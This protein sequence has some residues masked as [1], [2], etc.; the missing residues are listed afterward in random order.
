MRKRTAAFRFFLAA[1]LAVGLMP[2]MAFADGAE[3]SAKV[4]TEDSGEGRS[5]ASA[6]IEG[7]E[8]VGA[9][10]EGGASDASSPEES[11]DTTSDATNADPEEVEGLTI[12]SRPSEEVM[13]DAM[14]TLEA[15]S[16]SGFQAGML[17]AA[18]S[19]KA[20][21]PIQEYE[22]ADRFE[23]ACNVAEAAYPD[24]VS[25]AIIAGSEGWADALSATALAG[26]L[27]CPILLTEAD[28]LNE[29]T[30]STL[31]VLGVESVLIVGGPNTVSVDVEEALS[32][33]GFEVEK[34]LGGAD[35]YDV[36]MGIYEYG[37]G[38]WGDSAVIVASGAKF[39]DALSASPLAFSQ[40][41]PVFLVNDAGDLR[42]DQKSALGAGAGDGMFKDGVVVGGP[43]SVSEETMSFVQGVSLV[44]SGSLG[45]AVRLG[46]ADRYEASAN[47]A[48][49]AVEKGYLT[50]DGAAFT[51]GEKPY[52]ALTGS[53][54]QGKS[55]ATMLLVDGENC[56]TVE[57]FLA[58]GASS[59]TFF[60]GSASI[61]D[62]LRAHIA[63]GLGLIESYD[64]GITLSSFA[65]EEVVAS[66]GVQN[67][68]KSQILEYLDPSNFAYGSA[69]FYQFADVSEG[70]S[71]AVSADQID[72]FLESVCL[73]YGHENS[74]LLGQGAAFVAAAKKHGVNE[75]Y[76]LSRAILESGWGTSALAQ[77]EVTGYEG[78]YNFF[79]IGA[80]DIDPNNGGAALAKS[81]G[82]DTP[83]K[84][85]DGAAEWISGN[86]LNNEYH[87]N[88]LYKM[89]WCVQNVYH[90]YATARDWACNIAR[91]MGQVYDYIG[92]DAPRTGLTFLYPSYR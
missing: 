55:A 15:V 5:D 30:A 1:S 53:V 45:N 4:A 63:S 43:D 39:S 80:Y 11:I 72:A 9:I 86:Y 38:K 12:A 79:G 33:K 66:A 20:S 87:Q 25:R 48:Q 49:W 81:K 17:L 44:S 40:K 88:T 6:S 73:K 85:I 42:D 19:S 75:V 78:Y 41:V 84:A 32:A 77:G 51:T 22:G 29:G 54:L 47:F 71:G 8:A 65:D 83:A 92:Y 31:S 82:W 76:L 18:D 2:S 13:A 90:Q 59:V 14:E 34:R 67:Y 89:R 50:W 36:Q 3:D 27:D 57:A 26:A 24:G 37:K 60:G 35:R 58:S 21:G 64:C 68:S 28:S 56:P 62:S 69:N 52:D 74:T 91:V 70:Y 7:S 46:G 16:E 10:G 61:P 23:V